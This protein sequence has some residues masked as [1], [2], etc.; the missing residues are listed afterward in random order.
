MSMEPV[1]YGPFRLDLDTGQLFRFKVPIGQPLSDKERAVLRVIMEHRGAVA[2]FSAFPGS[3]REDVNFY[4]HA[5]GN[6]IGQAFSL[7]I[8]NVWGEGYRFELNVPDL[9]GRRVH[10]AGSGNRNLEYAH[11]P[12]PERWF[13]KSWRPVAGWW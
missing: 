9:T 11:A 3:S 10:I 13:A 2:R 5:I 8:Q 1:A 6:R 7:H 12:L 4:V